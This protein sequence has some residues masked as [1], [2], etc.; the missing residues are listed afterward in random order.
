MKNSQSG[1]AAL[2]L[3]LLILALAVVATLGLNLL[4][5]QRQ[6]AARQL[7]DAVQSYYVA[8]AG[9]EDSLLRLIN[10]D[11]THQSN[12]TLALNGHT[13]TITISEAGPSTTITSAGDVDNRIRKLSTQLFKNTVDANFFYGVQVG[14]GGL[15]IRHNDGQIV[16]N[17]Y[18]NGTAF[19]A[20]EITED[21]TVAGDG[22]QIQDLD[23]GGN[24]AAYAC[25]N[26]DITGNLIYTP[27]GTN[28]CDVN[29]SV[30][31]QA[32]APEPQDFPISEATIADWKATAAEAGT[33]TGNTT[34][35]S[36]QSLGPIKIDGNLTITNN[37]TLT[38][39]GIVWVTGSFS[40][41]NGAIVQLDSGYGNLSGPIIF[42]GTVDIDNNG[43][44][45]GSGDPES[46]L[47]VITTSNSEGEGAP[48]ID[49][50]NNLTG[51]I[52]Y[53]PNGLGVIHNNVAL[54]EIT[55][56]KL[57]LQKATVTYNSGLENTTF[58]SGPSGGY[59]FTSWREID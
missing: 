53:A 21:L 13:S 57:L 48:A 25:D 54:E 3:V 39:T 29:G 33:I 8:E 35:S 41:G 26:A 17:V 15:E 6:A 19:G 50:K 58:S 31:T 5:V 24:A 18:S 12:T 10:P 16:G 4:S 44:L 30:E 51:A 59:T 40:N 22:N 38:L 42:D 14:E 34:I 37:V 56:H 36:N 20:G 27:P 7:T 52:L 55:A 1:Q 47:L 2:I 45:R 32:S 23:I 46:F 28:D 11:Y 49:V 43:I 9:I